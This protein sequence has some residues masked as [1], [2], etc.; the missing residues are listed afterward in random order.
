MS[1]NSALLFLALP[2]DTCSTMRDFNQPR[3]VTCEHSP[4][5]PRIY[6]ANECLD[7]SNALKPC[8]EIHGC[9]CVQMDS[10]SHLTVCFVLFTVTL[11]PPE[12]VLKESCEVLFILLLSIE[13]TA[14]Q[15]LNLCHEM[16]KGHSS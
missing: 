12:L 16:R 8:E 11:G 3:T 9:F 15:S 13:V 5:V 10:W 7:T 14:S 4:F 2:T 1:Q 6:M